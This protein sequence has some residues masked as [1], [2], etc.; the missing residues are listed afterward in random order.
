[1]IR[2]WGGAAAEGQTVTILPR[3]SKVSDPHSAAG[4][5]S[6]VAT[7]ER[8]SGPLRRY[9]SVIQVSLWML[10]FGSSAMKGFWGGFVTCFSLSASA[11]APWKGGSEEAGPVEGMGAAEAV[12]AVPAAASSA[13]TRATAAPFAARA[14]RCKLSLPGLEHISAASLSRGARTLRGVSDERPTFETRAEA[15]A[16]CRGREAEEADSSWLVF[17]AED[18]RWTAARTDLPRHEDPTGTATAARPKPPEPD[19]PRSGRMRDIPPYGP[20]L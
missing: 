20:A 15:E 18:G 10:L 14:R 8:P 16:F 19:D 13:T 11:G 12:P 7:G 2:A 9:W 5:A 4:F 3:E 1:M 6:E 17:Q